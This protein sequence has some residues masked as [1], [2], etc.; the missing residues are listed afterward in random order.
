MERREKIIIAVMAIAVIIGGYDLLFKSSSVSKPVIKKKSATE[1]TDFVT[2]V[3]GGIREKDTKSDYIVRLASLAWTKDPFLQF[4]PAVESENNN[5]AGRGSKQNEGLNYSG[6]LKMG[7]KSLAVI[8][9]IE[10]E[11]GENLVNGEYLIEKVFP[12]RVVLRSSSS[13]NSITLFLDEAY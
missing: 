8:N 3:I 10:Y 1:L 13:S 7:A 11:E 5:R 12:A 4:D 9:G 2:S 6:Y